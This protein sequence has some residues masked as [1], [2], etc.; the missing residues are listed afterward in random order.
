VQGLGF[1][2]KGLG[3]RFE[4]RVIMPST[5]AALDPPLTEREKEGRGGGAEREKDCGREREV[6]REIDREMEKEERERD[7]KRE[8]AIARERQGD[9]E[10]EIEVRWVGE[11]SSSADSR[12]LF[13]DEVGV[14][15]DVG[16]I[17]S[18]KAPGCRRGSESLASSAATDLVSSSSPCSGSR[19]L[20]RTLTLSSNT[21][22][23]DS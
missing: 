20:R 9:K 16:V 3:F 14:R 10:A 19:I 7:R 22:H 23:S 5:P 21:L 12:H 15:G 1:R 17:Q 8:R 2:D 18:T 13:N 4:Q 6:E 11:R